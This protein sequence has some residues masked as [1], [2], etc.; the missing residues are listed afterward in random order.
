MKSII[1]NIFYYIPPKTRELL[2]YLKFIKNPII[3]LNNLKQLKKIYKLQKNDFKN[4][5]SPT[6]YKSLQRII[7]KTDDG[8]NFAKSF[9]ES[10][11]ELIKDGKFIV[12]KPILICLVKNDLIRIK[13]FHR[14]YIELGIRNFAFIDNDSND[15]TFE[16]LQ[17]DKNIAL[18]QIKEKYSTLNRQVWI[19]KVMNYYGYNNWY[20]IVDSDEFLIY[21]DCE[22]NKINSLITYYENQKKFRIKAL[23]IDM[24][25]DDKFLFESNNC[26]EKIMNK[27]CYFDKDTYISSKHTKFELIEGGVRKRVFEKYEKISPFLIKYP[28]IYF[29]P[30]D[31]QYNSH[32]SSPFYKNFNAE[33][34]IA[35]LHYK[36]MPEDLNKIKERVKEKNYAMGSK[37]Y[38]AY[39]KAYKEDPNIHLKNDESVKLITSNSIYAINLLK[40]INWNK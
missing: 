36:F 24:Y 4:I 34:N 14:Y 9:Y 11:I 32:Y 25:S 12:N 30:G 5:Q 10:R 38:S 23:M 26:K 29:Q 6:I 39:L 28:I 1:N 8:F 20:I 15:G 31:L 40:K 19:T 27:Y 33:L 16:Y 7:I 21:N 3:K 17:N 35:L 2:F 37:E 13:E 18:F 22:K